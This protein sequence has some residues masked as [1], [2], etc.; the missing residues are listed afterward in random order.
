MADPIGKGRNAAT[1]QGASALRE[2]RQR[3]GALSRG[4]RGDT[5]R[6][7][8]LS[9]GVRG[10]YPSHEKTQPG[11]ARGHP[12]HEKTQPGSARGVPLVCKRVATLGNTSVFPAGCALR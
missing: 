7:K 12:S 5:P 2:R 10:G 6:M 1:G 9:R 11:S 8:R 4:A 3:A